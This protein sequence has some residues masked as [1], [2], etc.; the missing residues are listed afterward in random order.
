MQIEIEKVKTEPYNF[1]QDGLPFVFSAWVYCR[2]GEIIEIFD[3]SVTELSGLVDAGYTNNDF[4]D[5]HYNGISQLIEQEDTG[6]FFL[7]GRVS[8]DFTQDYYGESDH[9]FIIDEVYTKEKCQNFAH[10]RYIYNSVVLGG[11]TI[12][13]EK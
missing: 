1:V 3:Y 4:F 11:V 7:S 8:S 6:L 13:E 12:T 10:L 9:S 2:N 5:I